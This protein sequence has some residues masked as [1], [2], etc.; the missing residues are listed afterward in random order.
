MKI[1]ALRAMPEA[2]IPSEDKTRRTSPL[3]YSSSIIGRKAQNHDFLDR[4]YWSPGM[5]WTIAIPAAM[6]QA[7]IGGFLLCRH[8]ED[9]TN[10]I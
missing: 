4:T 6:L 9:L 5:G 1:T 10:Q 2:M 3:T 8:R 7:G